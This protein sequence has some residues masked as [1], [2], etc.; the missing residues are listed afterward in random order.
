MGRLIVK[1]H[2]NE[3]LSK[4][5]VSNKEF[6]QLLRVCLSGVAG[7][8]PIFEMAQLFGKDVTLVR[9][10]HALSTITK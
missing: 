5:G 1:F 8:P 9:L 3:A 2:K 7:G 4:N 6:L 10:Q